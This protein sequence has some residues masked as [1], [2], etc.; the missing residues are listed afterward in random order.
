MKFTESTE[1]DIEQ[2]TEW[3]QNDPYHKDCMNPNWWLTGQGLLSFCAQDEEG[4]TMYIRT[5][6]DGN[7]LRFH[8]QFA[9]ETV[10]SKIR[11]AKS[12][13][14]GIPMLEVFAKSKGLIGLVYISISPTLISFMQMKFGFVP[15]GNDDHVKTFEVE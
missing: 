9:P 8:S 13:I 5:D 6:A 3:I 12:I 15:T 10:V 1:A 14:Q 4:P 7:L 11:V 2:L